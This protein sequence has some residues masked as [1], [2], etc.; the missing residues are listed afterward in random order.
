[1]KNS[2]F[3]FLNKIKACHLNNR[4]PK[5]EINVVRTFGDVEVQ[6]WLFDI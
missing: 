1:M 4:S 2:D 3:V 6:S 5:I